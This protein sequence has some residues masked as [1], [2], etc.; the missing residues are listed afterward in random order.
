MTYWQASEVISRWRSGENS[1]EIAS[2]LGLRESEVE[3]FIFSRVLRKGVSGVQALQ[4][5]W[6]M[7]KACE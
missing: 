4:P 1:H 7:Q 2:A 3:N 6:Q 5:V